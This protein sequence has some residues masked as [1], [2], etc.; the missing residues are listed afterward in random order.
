MPDFLALLTHIINSNVLFYIYLI[1]SAPITLKLGGLG[2]GVRSPVAKV[3]KPIV[4][5]SSVAPFV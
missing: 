3:F 4:L 2:F 5:A 1:L